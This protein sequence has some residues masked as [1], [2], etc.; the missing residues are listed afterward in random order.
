[1]AHL[2]KFIIKIALGLRLRRPGGKT[3]S[4]HPEAGQGGSLARILIEPCGEEGTTMPLTGGNHGCPLSGWVSNW[5]SNSVSLASR[6][7]AELAEIAVHRIVPDATINSS[8]VN[9]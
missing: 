8:S 6:R 4:L 5:S 3:G 9:R 2:G 1:L 7:R